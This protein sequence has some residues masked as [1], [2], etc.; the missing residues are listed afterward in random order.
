[1]KRLLVLLCIVFYCFANGRNLSADTSTPEGKPSC[2]KISFSQRTRL[3]TNDN[4]I[5]LDTSLHNGT[6]YTRHR[7][8]LSARWMP[9]NRFEFFFKW[10]NEF[11]YYFVPDSIEFNLHEVFVDNVYIKWT[12]PVGIPLILTAGRQDIMLGEGFLVMDANPLDG[13]RSAYFNGIRLDCSVQPGHVLTLFYVYQPV[14]DD[15]LPILHDQDQK[16][17]EQPED[18]I[19]LYYT[20]KKGNTDLEVYLIRK[21]I[22][23]TD[24]VPVRSGIN[25]VGGRGVFPLNQ[26]LT[27][28]GEMAYQFGTYGDFKRSAWG[29]YFYFDYRLGCALPLPRT[30]TLGTIALSGDNS[31]TDRMEAWDPLFSRWPKWSD[32][33]IYAVIP[34][35]GRRPAYWSNFISLYG[36]VVFHIAGPV[37]LEFTYH[38]LLA[39]EVAPQNQPFPG[40]TGKT[41]GDLFIIKPTFQ[42][43]RFVS[44]RVIWEIF[45]PGTFYRKDADSY[46]WLQVQFLTT[47]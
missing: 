36:G 31:K 17:V 16:M 40:G 28:T 34:E 22:R 47:F 26:K 25:T 23:S 11:R 39:P 13:S 37:N 46:N 10:S 1:M 7:N 20:G 41:R 35:K 14:S 5:G 27:L 2:L 30:C 12:L 15:L 42:L 29:G 9:N 4:T 43:C 3:E 21:S 44:G 19:G 6:T 32:S 8:S 24:A 38:R 33:Y 45:K 18:G